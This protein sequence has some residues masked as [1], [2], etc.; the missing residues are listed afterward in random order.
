M[1][2][3]KTQ[4][5]V[6]ARA[7]AWFKL[8]NEFHAKGISFAKMIVKRCKEESLTAFTRADAK[9]FVRTYTSNNPEKIDAKRLDKAARNA[10]A[11]LRKELRTAG[12]SV[13][14]DARGGANNKTGANGK[15]STSKAKPAVTKLPKVFEAI[16][17]LRQCADDLTVESDRTMFVHFLAMIEKQ[18]RAKTSK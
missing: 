7:Q 2:T 15:A 8:Y 13:E 4:N 18:E 6:A 16:A 10:L 12:V 9:A 14:V 5:A 17:L 11:W 3:N 1:K